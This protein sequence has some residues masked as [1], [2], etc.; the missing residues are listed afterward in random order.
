MVAIFLKPPIDKTFDLYRFLPL[1]VYFFISYFAFFHFSK[2]I[3]SLQKRNFRT[4][5][6]TLRS[7]LP[8]QQ[9]N[10][11]AYMLLRLVS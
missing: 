9:G 8:V 6:V 3:F 1:T 4:T 5:Q 7:F 11:V 2:L 10:G